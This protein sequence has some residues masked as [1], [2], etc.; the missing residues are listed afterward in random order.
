[1]NAC[2]LVRRMHEHRSWVNEKLLAT[3]KELTQPQLTTTFR[4]GQGSIWKTLC[5]L[6]AAEYVWLEAILGNENPTAPGDEPGKLPGNQEGE[7]AI[8]SLDELIERW[9]DL[10]VRWTEMLSTLTEECLDDQVVKFSPLTGRRS[11]TSRADILLHVC[12]HAQYTTAQLINM[13]RQFGL[14]DLPDVMLITLSRA[15]S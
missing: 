3:S 15:G 6:Y 12:T 2:D 11:A 13:L 14:D 9:Q 4:I 5:H 8:A 1:M 7:D 10:E